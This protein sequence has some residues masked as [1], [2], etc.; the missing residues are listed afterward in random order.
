MDKK[1]DKHNQVPGEAYAE[2]IHAR[3]WLA[4][5]NDGYVGIGRIQLLERIVVCGSIS[6]A[7][8]GMGMS[9]KKAWKLVEE[10]NSMYGE[11][12]VIKLQGGKDGGGTVVT[13]RGKAVIEAFREL[14][15]ELVVFLQQM[16]QKYLSESV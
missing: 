7:A 1:V 13:D 10:M 9:Y 15:K 8:K 6:Q 3:F 5:E 2:K 12:L 16:Q 4:G 11:P 14:E